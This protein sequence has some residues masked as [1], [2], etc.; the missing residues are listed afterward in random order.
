MLKILL[1]A[2][3]IIDDLGAI[4][5]IALFYTDHLETGV[6]LFCLLPIAVMFMMNRIGIWQVAP[7]LACGTILWAAVLESGVHAT[8]AGVITAL[9]IPNSAPEGQESPLSKLEHDLA[10]WVAFI[11]MPVFAF[12]NAGVP[13]QGMGLDALFHPLTLG[14]IA[15]LFIGKQIGIFGTIWVSVKTGLCPKPDGVNWKQLY[16]LSLLCGV[17]FTMSLFIGGLAFTDGADTQNAV[18]LGVLVGSV[19]SAVSG[20]ILLKST[21]GKAGTS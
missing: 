4:I 2:I 8:L 15:G 20:Y 19:L 3:A 9:F 10:P 21:T 17:G 14:I 6:L 11:V 5:V 18:R 1:L 7:Y 12:A 16:G 13:L